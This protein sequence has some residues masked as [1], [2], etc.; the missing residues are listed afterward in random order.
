MTGPEDG[1][2]PR[3]L[4]RLAAHRSE[5]EAGFDFGTWR[6]GS[7]NADGVIQMPWFDFSPEATAFLDDVRGSGWI[8]AFDWPAWVAMPEGRA[9]TRDPDAIAR[10]SAEDLSRILTALIRGDRFS[11]GALAH[12][13][14]S[15]VLLAVVR[16]AAVLLEE[17]SSASASGPG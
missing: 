2:Q 17:A 11:E 7:A 14:E 4:G 16:R 13:Y 5:F 6:G 8:E 1:P 3:R 12:A 15:G 10:A 9:L